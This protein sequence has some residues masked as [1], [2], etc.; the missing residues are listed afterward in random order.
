M[1]LTPSQVINNIKRSFNAYLAAGLTGSTINFDGNSF[2]TSGLD[3][4]YSV[5]YLEIASDPAGMGDV[6]GTDGSTGNIHS[7]KA[8][9]GAWHRDDPQGVSSGDMIDKIVDL[10]EESQVTFYDWSDPEDPVES[11]ELALYAGSGS[12]IPFGSDMNLRDANV[13][14]FLIEVE[15]KIV[16]EEQ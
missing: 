4:W 6:I 7:V 1:T 15:L 8:E 10:L 5:R 11:G 12:F 3:S 13:R 2:N 9:V 14:G 16:A